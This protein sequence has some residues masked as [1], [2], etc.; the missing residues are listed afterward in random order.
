MARGFSKVILVGNLAR[1]PEVRYSNDGNAVAKFA[2]AVNNSWKDKNGQVHED[3][4]FINTV[5]FGKT[6]EACEK[7][8][9]KGSPALVEGRLK[10]SSYEA[11]DGSGKRYSTDVV[12]SLV[13]FLGGKGNGD[14]AVKEKQSKPQVAE[15]E[16]Q[17][18]DD[19]DEDGNFPF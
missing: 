18:F 10:V 19:E 9:H 16:F 6:A 12:A 11:K 13:L 3:V 7:F 14:E 8:L 17:P 15:E 5:V 1:D 4:D 2:V